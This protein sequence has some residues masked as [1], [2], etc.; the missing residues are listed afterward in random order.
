MP[1]Q[2]ETMKAVHANN[3]ILCNRLQGL[4]RTLLTK[5]HKFQAQKDKSNLECSAIIGEINSYLACRNALSPS[6]SPDGYM[7]ELEGK[8]RVLVKE[9]E[10]IHV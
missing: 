6:I 9:L 3:L 10:V 7:K 1:L 4:A 2:H 5:V 8:V